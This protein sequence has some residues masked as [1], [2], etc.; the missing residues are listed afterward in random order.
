MRHFIALFACSLVML[1]ASAN[2][3][4][5]HAAKPEADAARKLAADIAKPASAKPAADKA[6]KAAPAADKAAADKAAALAIARAADK[7]VADKAAAEK[8]PK[9]EKAVEKA[10]EKPGKTSASTADKAASAISAASEEDAEVDLSVRI[11]ERLAE[12]RAKQAARM[13][14]AAKAKKAAEAKRK[15][16]AA[17]AAAVAVAAAAPKI[18]NHWDYEGEFGPENWGKINPAWSQCG[19]GKRQSP[20]DIRDGMKVSLDEIDFNYRYSDYTEVDNG[21]T[22]QVNVGRGNFMTIGN[23]SYELV[24]FHFHR[25]SEEKING[26]G[27]EMVIHLEHRGPGGKLAIVAVLL[28]RGK[29]NDAIQT[30]WNNIPLEKNQQVAS[31]EPLDPLEL[32]PERREYYTYMGSQ[33]TPPCAENVLWLVMKQPMTA[34]PAQMALFSR[35]YPLNARPVQ[36]SEGRMVKESN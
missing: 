17:A 25:P 14:A 9:G 19:A 31:S 16:E 33:T 4:P 7:S 13:A 29:A 28:E 5:A 20:I 8:E 23:Q 22:V 6:D 1:H 21:K 35:L 30:V 27:T 34:S 32:L 12:M 18:S 24:Q 10:V 26:K 15:K 3:P 11:A 2:E 36:E